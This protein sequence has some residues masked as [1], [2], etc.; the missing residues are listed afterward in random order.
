[1]VLYYHW[2]TFLDLAKAIYQGPASLFHEVGNN[3]CDATGHPSH[4]MH[5]H[6]SRRFKY[7]CFLSVLFDEVESLVEIGSQIEVLF[8]VGLDIQVVGQV[9]LRVR[10]KT[11]LGHRHYSRN[12]EIYIKTLA[13]F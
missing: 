13:Y 1:M 11:S 7:I 6:L 5:E 9:V 3:D 10:Q 4:T 2:A 8:V 12:F